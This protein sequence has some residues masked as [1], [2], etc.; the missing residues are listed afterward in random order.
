MGVA[1]PSRDL[2]KPSIYSIF[3]VAA[4]LACAIVSIHSKGAVCDLG[5]FSRRTSLSNSSL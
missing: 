3:V 1:V 2:T 4:G 5:L